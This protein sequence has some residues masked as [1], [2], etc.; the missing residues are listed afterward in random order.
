MEMIRNWWK[1][2]GIRVLTGDGARNWEVALRPVT[3]EG[4][5]IPG[6][7]GS[8]R[9]LETVARARDVSVLL[10]E[11][12]WGGMGWARVQMTWHVDNCLVVGRGTV[13]QV[14]TA[15]PDPEFARRALEFWV[16]MTV[17]LR[18]AGGGR[19]LEATFRVTMS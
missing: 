16:G 3:R 6:L 7:L 17:D 4:L 13:F 18:T 11:G 19:A 8:W 15:L 14:K 2:L 9:D 1:H 10:L 5:R 12:D